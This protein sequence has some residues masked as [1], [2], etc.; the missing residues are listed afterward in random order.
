MIKSLSVFF[1][2]YNEEGNIQN[3]VERAVNVLKKLS[4]EW[5]VLIINDGSRDQTGEI[6]DKLAQENSQVK[7]VHQKN[8][9]YGM[10]LRAG[11]NH[12][13]YDWI[14]YTDADGQFDFTQVP[15]FL[16]KAQ[17]NDYIVG[18]RTKRNDPFYRI[19][20][21]KGWALSVF[22]LF[23]V[24]VKD[25]DCGFKMVSRE[26]INAIKPLES[27]RGAMINAELLIK[28]KKKGFRITQVGVDHYPRV[29]GTPSGASI[30]V[31]LKSYIDLIK[32]WWKLGKLFN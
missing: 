24:W 7:A 9:G 25:I 32:L 2:A 12:S 20:F 17:E 14:V 11:F 6:A 1:P 29:S 19:L 27:T 8:G 30:K 23:G 22:L 21:A 28:A 15:K 5:E 3:T 26:V 31:I 4:L 10:A 16:E 13:K 18:F